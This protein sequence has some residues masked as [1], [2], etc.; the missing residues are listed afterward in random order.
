MSCTTTRGLLREVNQMEMERSREPM[1]TQQYWTFFPVLE[2]TF[3]RIYL[4][5]TNISK[6][7]HNPFL[8]GPISSSPYPETLVISLRGEITS[9]WVPGHSLHQSCVASQHSYLF[10][11]EDIQETYKS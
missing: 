4:M 9:H 11:L 3:F 1:A 8:C 5:N 6:R 10:C 7:I 2:S